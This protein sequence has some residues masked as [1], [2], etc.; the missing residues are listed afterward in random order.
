LTARAGG[1]G[2]SFEKT[3]TISGLAARV[4]GKGGGTAQEKKTPRL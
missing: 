2:R 3:A 1:K 4:E